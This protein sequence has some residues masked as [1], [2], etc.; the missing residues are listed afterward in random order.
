MPFDFCHSDGLGISGESSSL[1]H[2]GGGVMLGEY[3]SMGSSTV[4][5]P[6]TMRGDDEW[7]CDKTW[8]EPLQVTDREAQG[9][10]LTIGRVKG[11]GVVDCKVE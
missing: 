7:E 9:M 2:G 11:E 10:A 5:A 6:L 1:L 8:D 3:I 4:P